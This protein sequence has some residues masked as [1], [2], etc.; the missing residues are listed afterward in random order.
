[1]EEE[2]TIT[3]REQ[4]LVITSAIILAGIVSNYT[5]VGPSS[6]H[7]IVAKCAARDILANILDGKK[8]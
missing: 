5:T 8:L 4:L 3:P 7:I 2:K 6:T 1:M